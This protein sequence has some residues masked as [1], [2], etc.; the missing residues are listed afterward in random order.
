M[1]TK[2]PQNLAISFLQ[3]VPLFERNLSSLV[4]LRGGNSKAFRI[5]RA[6][7]EFATTLDPLIRVSTDSSK[8]IINQKHQN[9]NNY[10]NVIILVPTWHNHTLL[11]GKLATKKRKNIRP[12]IL[13][14][15]LLWPRIWPEANEFSPE[16]RPKPKRKPANRL[17]TI[18]F[19]VLLLL[20]SGSVHQSP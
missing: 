17:P 2:Y 5:F 10:R 6:F 20:V 18:H 4:F 1:M 3:F 14:W 16:N 9:Q 19:Q 15:Q 7:Q 12:W 13:P 11:G 8:E